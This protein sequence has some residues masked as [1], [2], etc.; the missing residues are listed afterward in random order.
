MSGSGT[1]MELRDIEIFLTLAEELHF[2]RTA[3]RLH[4]TQARVSQAI[5]KQERRIGAALFERNNRQVALTPIGQRL[6]DDIQPMYRGLHE[7]MDRAR[8]AARGK[9]GV[10]RVGSI[11]VNLHDFR[12]LFDGFAKDHPECEVQLRHVDFGDPFGQLRAGDIDVQIVWLPVKEPDLTVGPVI[13]TEPIVLAVGATHRLAGRESVSYEDLADETVMGGARPD[14]WREI[15]VPVR[16]PSGR[17][18]PIGPSVSNFQEMIPILVTGEAVSPVHAQAARYYARPDL[19]YVPIHDAPPGRWGL[20]W[21]T[22][23]ETELIRSFAS[24]ARHLTSI[25]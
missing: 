16:T 13:Y 3:E 15:L 9:T 7:G 23:N 2:T 8:L 17:L 5:R 20:I 18:I 10:L 12:E 1:V 6:F 24:A 14:Y 25:E 4:V 21:R 22:G 11:A 19:A